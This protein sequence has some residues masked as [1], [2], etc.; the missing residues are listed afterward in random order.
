MRLS[1]EARKR[2]N[3]YQAVEIAAREL[4][5]KL[6]LAV[7]AASKGHN[8]LI[9][10]KE[11]IMRAIQ[12]GDLAPG[13]FH[14]KSLVPGDVKISRH[15]SLIDRGCLITSIDEEGGLID[16]GYEKFAVDR[17]SELTVAQTSAVFGW[18]PEDTQTLKRVYKKYSAN[19]YQTGSPR[20]DLWRSKF[21]QYWA[22]PKGM[23]KKPYLLISSNMGSANN[24]R[25]VHQRLRSDRRGNCNECDDAILSRR[26]GRTVEEYRMIW[27][28]VQAI[29]HLAESSLKYDIVL[30]PHPTE[31]VEAW[32]VYLE[33]VPN[34]HVIREGSIT[35][36]VK[37]A[38]AI[39][40]NGCTTALEATVS[41]KPV[42]TYMPFEQKYARD[43]PNELGAQVQSPDVLLDTVNQI[44][45]ASQFPG[46]NVIE[47]S[48]PEIVAKK[49]Y[50][51]NEQLAAEK[52]VEVWENLDNG[53]LSRQC[54]WAKFQLVLKLEKLTKSWRARENY[55]F[56]PIDALDIA[57]RIQRLQY[58]IGIDRQLKCEV[59]SDRTIL[60]RPG[61]D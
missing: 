27:A 7:V 50:L 41:G 61:T 4:D 52:I 29:R 48:Q 45:Y 42:V 15:Q 31:N 14:T 28:F 44:F 9:S 51:D 10:E 32:K 37:H 58:I 8:V 5:G 56:P 38:F 21:L 36:W 60:I 1:S 18:G 12:V 2:M 23:P 46:A 35:A 19:V 24:V 47:L 26:L 33:G 57:D 17:Y 59:L 11:T 30:R 34:V 3:I 25:P 54:R 20:A 16:H 49:I 22:P 13:I 40:H 53:R 6:L 43:L 39:M 55:K